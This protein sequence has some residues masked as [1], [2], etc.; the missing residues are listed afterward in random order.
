MAVV[1]PIRKSVKAHQYVYDTIVYVL[2]PENKHGDEKCFKATCLNCENESA[3]SLAK[4]FYVTRKAFKKD[5]DILAHHYVQSFSPNENVTPELA[6]QIGVE[7]MKKV[8]PN[9]QVIVSTHVDKD[10]I[11]NHI[12]INSVNM[13]TGNKWYRNK[14]SIENMWKES[15][16]L[17]R[18]YGLSTI[19]KKSG[20]RGIDQTTQKLAEKGQ[21]WK[22][23]LCKALDEVT[24]LCNRK[25]NFIHYMEVKGFKI[26]RYG[27]K[28]ITFQKI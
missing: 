1:E 3:E 5:D 9:F 17:C 19:E 23:E 11:H 13:V 22:V 12:V 4:Q 6:H 27:E 25:D 20:L 24:S 16:S 7:L 28:D 26:T 14:N 15:D 18:K 10:H 8:A 2:S 21:S